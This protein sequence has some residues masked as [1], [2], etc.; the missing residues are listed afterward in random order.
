VG[1][2]IK[3]FLNR[4]MGHSKVSLSWED[5]ELN[6]T[7]ALKKKNW[8]NISQA[9]L[10]KIDWGNYINEDDVVEEEQRKRLSNIVEKDDGKGISDWRKSNNKQYKNK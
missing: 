5:P 10:D 1:G 8:N 4:A 7:A 6:L 2:E 9:D 3:N